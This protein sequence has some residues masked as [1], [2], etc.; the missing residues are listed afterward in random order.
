[1]SCVA[2]SRA[3]PLL[4]AMPSRSL[5]RRLPGTRTA[6]RRNFSRALGV[7]LVHGVQAEAPVRQVACDYMCF[8][9][10]GWV[11]ADGGTVV[12][13]GHE[14]DTKRD[15]RSTGVFL[16]EHLRS[17]LLDGRAEDLLGLGVESEV[18]RSCAAQARRLELWRRRQPLAP[19]PLP[20][21]PRPL[22]RRC[23]AT[24]RSKRD[25]LPRCL[26]N[27]KNTATTCCD[28]VLAYND[29]PAPVVAMGW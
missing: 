20:P 15:E 8:L 10:L 13:C 19:R 24:L 27:L 6:S 12:A 14:V 26:D 2:M 11:Q 22:K 17:E 18:R 7:Q 5:Q 16:G 4:A 9:P 29:P 21:R 23:P 1:M 3:P 25:V 28:S